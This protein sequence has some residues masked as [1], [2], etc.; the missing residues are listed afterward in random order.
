MRKVQWFSCRLSYYETSGIEY[1]Q[2][3]DACF[4]DPDDTVDEP[5]T[6]DVDEMRRA[7]Q[8]AACTSDEIGEADE[9]DAD[10]NLVK[11]D[12]AKFVLHAESDED[13]GTDNGS[14]GLKQLALV[15]TGRFT[16]VFQGEL[17]LTDADGDGG[18]DNWGR[19]KT[20]ATYTDADD[21]A[22]TGLQRLRS[23]VLVM[24]R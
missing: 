21:A 5:K 19:A 7:S 2:G 6:T 13:A 4:D 20:S 17:R 9:F 16:G 15:E 12:N 14:G 3:G 1:I 8:Q 10:S 22:M 11:S 24:V 23:W 18:G